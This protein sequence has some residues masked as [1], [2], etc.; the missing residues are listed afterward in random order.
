MVEVSNHKSHDYCESRNATMKNHQLYHIKVARI[1]GPE[2]FTDF[3]N[4]SVPLTTYYTEAQGTLKKHFIV[5]IRTSII[6]C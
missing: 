1:G 5:A 4:K 2:I 3:P 6:T